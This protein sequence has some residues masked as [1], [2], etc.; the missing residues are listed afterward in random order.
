MGDS[1]ELLLVVIIAILL[2]F[3]REDV[4]YLLSMIANM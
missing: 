4:V 3:G 1:S 2:W